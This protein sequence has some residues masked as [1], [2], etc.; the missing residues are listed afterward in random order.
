MTPRPQRF[1]FGTV[2]ALLLLGGFAVS[3]WPH[4]TSA[5]IVHIDPTPPAP[6]LSPQPSARTQE[7]YQPFLAP[8][9]HVPPT[10]WWLSWALVDTVQ[11]TESGSA[12]WRQPNDP[13]SM[14]KAWIAAD[15]LRTHPHPDTATLGLLSGMIRDSVD[16]TARFY[17][18]ALGGSATTARLISVCGLTDV[19]SRPWSWST[20]Q[21]S[22]RDAVRLGV[23]I[24][25]GRAAGLWTPWLLD[26]MRHVRGE[27]DFGIRAAFPELH[28]AIAIK[29]GWFVW[30]ADGTTW[31]VNCLAIGPTWVLAVEQRGAPSLARAGDACASVAKALRAAAVGGTVE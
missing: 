26:E 5:A 25:D 23:C 24:V 20:T 3:T 8:S 28:D 6:A 16:T 13:M 4:P 19:V 14:M 10:K 12:N 9:D 2:A 18:D 1:L 22:A 15:W 30:P 31:E 7:R 27:G 17:W 11:G 29:N 21:L